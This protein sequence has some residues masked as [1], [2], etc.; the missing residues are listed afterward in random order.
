MAK[1]SKVFVKLETKHI[2]RRYK[3]AAIRHRKKLG[4]K[5]HLRIHA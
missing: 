2:K 4:P 3:P 5:H 1:K